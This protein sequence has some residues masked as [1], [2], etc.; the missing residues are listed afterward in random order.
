MTMVIWNRPHFQA[1]HTEGRLS[2]F[3]TGVQADG[4][5]RV[6]TVVIQDG[7]SVTVSDDVSKVSDSHR[8]RVRTLLDMAARK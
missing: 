6:T 1:R 8:G 3:A 4:N 7:A 5:V 2:I